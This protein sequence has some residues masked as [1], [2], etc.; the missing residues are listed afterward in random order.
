[1]DRYNNSLSSFGGYHSMNI[2]R[3]P[4]HMINYIQ[5]NKSNN[6]NYTHH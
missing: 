6:G 1:M 5:R 4:P 2:N 3:R